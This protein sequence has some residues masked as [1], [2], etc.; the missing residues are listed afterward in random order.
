MGHHLIAT[1]AYIDP[2]TG[3]LLFQ[4]LVAGLLSAGLFMKD[5]RVKIRMMFAGRK[6]PDALP[7]PTTP[8]EPRTPG[9]T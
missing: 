9:G 1:L 7:A 3:S 8:D 5:L 2:G 4:M 6:K